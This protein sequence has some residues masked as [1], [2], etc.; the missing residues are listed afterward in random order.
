MTPADAAD[1]DADTCL[2]PAPLLLLSNASS[3]LPYLTML[4]VTY[5]PTDSNPTCQLYLILLQ[6]CNS[7]VTTTQCS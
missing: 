6:S 2:L 3:N 5:I 7:Q 4:D 1:A